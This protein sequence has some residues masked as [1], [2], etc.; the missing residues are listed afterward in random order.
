MKR[1]SPFLWIRI[2]PSF[3][4]FHALTVTAKRKWSIKQFSP[5][6]LVFHKCQN[7]QVSLEGSQ[8]LL[9]VGALHGKSGPGLQ[10]LFHLQF[11]YYQV[12]FPIVTFPLPD[13]SGTKK[14]HLYG[15][16]SSEQDTLNTLPSR[17]QL[18]FPQS[19]HVRCKQ[20]ICEFGPKCS[21]VACLLIA[22]KNLFNSERKGRQRG[23]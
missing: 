7:F 3:P 12:N 15:A 19:T 6:S 11:D 9:K 1:S 2:L 20:G 4:L 10:N 18:F 13:I 5:V 22:S 17:K 14:Q 16:V 21:T 8:Q 23:G